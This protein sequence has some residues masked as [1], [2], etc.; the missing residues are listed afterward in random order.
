MSLSDT[1]SSFSSVFTVVLSLLTNL[2]S[3]VVQTP[4]VFIPVCLLLVSFVIG[5][6]WKLFTGY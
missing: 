5:L 4:L 3:W 6:F 2:A 1:L